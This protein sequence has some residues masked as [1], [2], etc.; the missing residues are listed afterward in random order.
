MENSE[1]HFE[2]NGPTQKQQE[3]ERVPWFQ[4]SPL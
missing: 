1:E 3:Q 2:V 4:L